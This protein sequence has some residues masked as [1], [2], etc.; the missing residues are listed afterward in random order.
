MSYSKMYFLKIK[1]MISSI[2]IPPLYDFD[3][4]CKPGQPTVPSLE[5]GKLWHYVAL[6]VW[7]QK[8][9]TVSSWFLSN[10]CFVTLQFWGEK[11]KLIP[12]S[13]FTKF[14]WFANPMQEQ[15]SRR[16]A[17]P[18]VRGKTA[19]FLGRMFATFCWRSYS[20]NPDLHLNENM[21]LSD[22]GQGKPNHSQKIIE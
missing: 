1:A 16:V 7:H 14:I 5:L 8:T 17:Q 21:V 12:H 13:I 19:E 20:W 11:E 2:H 10:P 18:Q 3:T 9:R 15:S 22:C 6:E 4:F